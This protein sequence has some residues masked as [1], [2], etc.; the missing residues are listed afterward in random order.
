MWQHFVSTQNVHILMSTNS[1][2]QTRNF[3]ATYDK[4]GLRARWQSANRKL[5]YYVHADNAATCIRKSNFISATN[6]PRA[7]VSCICFTMFSQALIKATDEVSAMQ[8][9]RASIKN[10]SIHSPASII[11]GHRFALRLGLTLTVHGLSCIVLAGKVLTGVSKTPPLKM[12]D[13]SEQRSQRR[14]SELLLHGQDIARCN[15]WLTIQCHRCY[16]PPS[17][18]LPVR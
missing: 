17:S 3:I 10:N 13:I 5:C 14:F 2:P 9:L 6:G 11:L 7:A 1:T 12:P 18:I 16:S 8:N 15:P 4:H